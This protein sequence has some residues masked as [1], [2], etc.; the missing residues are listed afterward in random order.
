MD[1]LDKLL[2]DISKSVLKGA[3]E[4]TRLLSA[5]RKNIL[6]LRRRRSEHEPVP[7]NEKKIIK[8]GREGRA[9]FVR[10]WLDFMY[11]G[12]SE[13]AVE[14]EKLIDQMPAEDQNLQRVVLAE[15][16]AAFEM[17]PEEP[18]Y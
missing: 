5:A 10:P 11:D 17:F 1:D 2:A 13:H 14:L 16:R 7:I 18:S 6:W 9:A 4:E 3:S 15:L 12:R 8:G